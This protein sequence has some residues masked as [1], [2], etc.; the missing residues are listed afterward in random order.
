MK[1]PTE[2]Q[3]SRQHWRDT[4]SLSG[5]GLEI[6]IV[7]ANLAAFASLS[8]LFVNNSPLGTIAVAV[9]LAH[10]IAISSRW[11]KLPWIISMLIGLIAIGGSILGALLPETVHHLVIPTHSTWDVIERSMI[12]A[13][14]V[15]LT[16]KAPTEPLLGFTLLAALGAWFIVSISDAIAF[17]LG[18]LIEA[19][20]PPGVVVILV[21]AL[22]PAKN[23]LPSLL[24]FVAAVALVVASARVRELSREAW[25]GRRPKRA[26][27]P[28]A[29]LF[30]GTALSLVAYT[31]LRPPTWVVN[32]LVNLR[33]DV[34]APRKSLRTASNPMVS[35]RAHL[36]DLPDADLFIAKTSTRSY[37]RLTAL[38]TYANDQWTAERGSYKTEDKAVPVNRTPV[39]ITLL[40]GFNNEWLPSP[41]LPISVTGKHTDGKRADVKFDRSTDSV[42]L[43]ESHRSG[44]VY[45]VFGADP[46]TAP[47]RAISSTDRPKLLAVPSDVPE[48]VTELARSVTAG[49]STE[50][51]KMKLLEAF[52]RTNFV[53]DLEIAK[54]DVL[55]IERFL[56]DVKR[57]YCEQFASSFAVMARTLGLPA[58][59]AVGF[60]P[61]ES[62]PG[63][64]YRVRGRDAHTWPEVYINGSWRSFEPTPSRGSADSFSPTTTTTTIPPTTT[65]QSTNTPPTTIAPT[66]N[67]A[68]T[69]VRGAGISIG[70]LLRFLALVGAVL[71]LVGIPT[72]VRTWRSRRGFVA[73]S[74]TLDPVAARAWYG[75][76]DDL[77]WHGL[78]RGPA[79]ATSVWLRRIRK[80]QASIDWDRLTAIANRVES[81]R[82]APLTDQR[83]EPMAPAPAASN[84]LESTIT[85]FRGS[86]NSSLPR[87]VRITRMMSFS[88]RPQTRAARG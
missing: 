37:W 45:S 55:G 15:F 48:N 66:Q 62:L 64:L 73:D 83:A 41:A 25:L 9:L 21:A 31:T 43:P 57:G 72:M 40:K 16:V 8:R 2:T 27:A 59:V 39:Q 19:L 7:L 58:R 71:L 77:A 50:V 34:N 51:E 56:F 47:E 4:F 44:D 28:G 1:A 20:V 23:R 12:E 24:A 32:G 60:V 11:A 29:L 35:T 30:I 82:Y 14:N 76:E 17:R 46:A 3:T 53:Y 88:P 80:S 81:A 79:E 26:G 22:A 74:E 69:K 52:F 85:A 49:G 18:F 65:A 68:K 70:T 75:L 87:A 61:G 42:L 84:D 10:G 5:L 86:C 67:V 78:A 36:V 54:V 13:W 33:T 63:G 38:D 6:G